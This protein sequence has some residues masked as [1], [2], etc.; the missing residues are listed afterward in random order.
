M[1]AILT[2]TFPIFAIIAV[3]YFTVR[4]GVFDPGSLKT[5]GD[6][7]MLIALPMLLFRAT[8][9][10]QISELLNPSYLAILAVGSLATQSLAWG[11]TWA[12]GMGPARRGMA[13]LGAATP[14]SAFLGYPIIASVL[15]DHAAPI[16]A[17]NLLIENFVLTPVGLTLIAFAN[18]DRSS[19]PALA[20]FL[21]KLAL[22]V[23]RRPLIIGLILGVG[24]V[25]AGIEIPAWLDRFCGL[26]GGAASPIALFV[27][28]GSLVGLPMAGNVSLAVQ[29]SAVKLIGHPALVFGAGMVLVALGLPDPGGSLRIGL[30]LSAALPMF[31]IYTLFAREVGYEGIASM[32]LVIATTA[33]FVTLNALL[34]V[35]I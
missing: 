2:L 24:T 33:A 19:R 22:S 18:S 10:L 21:G 8:A 27:I 3:G 28:G 12:Q 17:M 20:P 31:S 15:P 35:L 23:L 1:T 16:L 30:L 34:F 29:I 25:L 6:F 11:L 5:M 32:A 13:V 14:N 26:L 4:R 9:T 7:V